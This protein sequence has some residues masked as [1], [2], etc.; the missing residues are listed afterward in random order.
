M[1]G[2]HY[3]NVRHFADLGVSSVDTNALLYKIP[4]DLQ[5]FGLSSQM[6]L[7]RHGLFP[8]PGYTMR[9]TWPSSFKTPERTG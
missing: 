6:C 9:V 7:Y 8:T 4:C 2:F 1:P 5:D 3:S